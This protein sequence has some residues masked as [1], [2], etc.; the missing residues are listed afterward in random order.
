MLLT[1]FIITKAQYHIRV[2][3]F[4]NPGDKYDGDKYSDYKIVFTNDNWKRTT[5]LNEAFDIS[6]AGDIN[7]VHQV[8]L[9]SSMYTSK[10]DAI[11]FARQLTTYAKCIEWNKQQKAKYYE[12]L[13][14]RKAHPIPLP[15]RIMP[16]EKCCTTTKIY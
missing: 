1:S 8:K 15:K 12:L 2:D 13:A 16:K 11:Q 4:Y 7:V 10:S 5:D 9:F 14:Y 3:C 6:S